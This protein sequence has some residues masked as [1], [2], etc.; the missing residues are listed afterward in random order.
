MVSIV[1]FIKVEI[2]DFDFNL[3]HLKKN[4]LSLEYSILNVVKTYKLNVDQSNLASVSSVSFENQ[5]KINLNKIRMY[6]FFTKD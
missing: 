5:N 4:C 6:Y 3:P 1:S 2:T